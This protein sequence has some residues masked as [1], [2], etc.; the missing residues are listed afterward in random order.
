MLVRMACV[1][2]AVSGVARRCIT[3]GNDLKAASGVRRIVSPCAGM[4]PPAVTVG[5]KRIRWRLRVRVGMCAR[6]SGRAVCCIGA[7]GPRFVTTG[8]WSMKQQYFDDPDDDAQLQAE[9]SRLAHQDDDDDAVCSVVVLVGVVPFLV[10][11]WMVGASLVGVVSD[12]VV[13]VALIV[14][15]VFNLAL[16]IGLS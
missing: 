9:L 8:L 11:A 1:S 10:L 16:M 2:D 12:G 13:G 3:A 15:A 6:G 5:L 4:A 7:C 14:F